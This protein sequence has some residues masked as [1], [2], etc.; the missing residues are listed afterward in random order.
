MRRIIFS[1]SF[2]TLACLAAC[3]PIRSVQNTVNVVTD[4]GSGSMMEAG[5]ALKQKA[6]NLKNG[7]EKIDEGKKQIEDTLTQ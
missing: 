3:E 7:L 2:I 5:M 6:Q 4:M 1:L